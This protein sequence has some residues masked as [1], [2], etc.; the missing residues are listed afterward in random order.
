MYAAWFIAMIGFSCSWV[1]II[2]KALLF[3]CVV[4]PILHYILIRWRR[5]WKWPT[6]I[7]Q[8]RT[9]TLCYK[10]WSMM[11]ALYVLQIMHIHSDVVQS[12]FHPFFLHNCHLLHNSI[13]SVLFRRFGWYYQ[14]MLSYF[15]NFVK[16]I[17]GHVVKICVRAQ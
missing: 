10:V 6:F 7:C 15:G 13:A 17:F 8:R 9:W 14:L 2:L 3:I 1:P 16:T 4:M 11:M 12:T 5:A